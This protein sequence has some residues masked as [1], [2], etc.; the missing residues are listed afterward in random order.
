MPSFDRLTAVPVIVVAASASMP[1]RPPLMWPPM[2]CAPGEKLR[3]ASFS[4]PSAVRSLMI[5][6]VVPAVATRPS[7]PPLSFSPVATTLPAPRSI[8]T[9]VRASLTLTPSIVTS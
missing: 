6:P 5:R 1:V 8:R 9:P 7:C 4:T 3:T 2:I